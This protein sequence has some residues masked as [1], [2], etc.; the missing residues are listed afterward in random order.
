[1]YVER[2][3]GDIELIWRV[4]YEYRGFK[5]LILVRGTENEMR[6]YM[7]SEMGYVGR[8]SACSDREIDAAKVLKLPVYI[9]PKLEGEV[10]HV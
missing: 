7:D 1:M 6:A 8:Y 5:Q 9:A 3:N 4:E 2:S 10:I